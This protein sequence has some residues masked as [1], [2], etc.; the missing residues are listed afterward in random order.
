MLSFYTPPKAHIHHLL[1]QK[2]ASNQY[3]PYTQKLSIK[4]FSIPRCRDDVYVFNQ[5]P[6]LPLSSLKK[7]AP[8]T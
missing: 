7:T 6:P 8:F 1:K 5:T 3:P 2:T 4:S